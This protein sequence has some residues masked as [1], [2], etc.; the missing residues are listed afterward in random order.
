MNFTALELSTTFYAIQM[1][2]LRNDGIVVYVN[3]VER[4]RN[5]MPAGGVAYGTLASANI[6]PGAAEA[7]TTNLSPSFFVAG[8]N[9]IAVEVH[10][11]AANSTDMSFDMQVSG[12]DNNGTFNSS[13]AN[14]NI[15]SCSNILFAG[16]YWGA[17][18]GI[19]GTDSTWMTAGFNTVKLKLPGAAN[20]QTLTST[21]T[22]RH[23][24]AWSTAGFN[25][26]GYMCF[27]DITS[28][29]NASNAIFG[30][31]YTDVDPYPDYLDI[32]SDDDGIPDNVEGQSTTGYRLPGTVDTDGDGPVNTY[33]NIAGFSG[34]GI[35]VYD[36]DGDNTPDYRDSD[37]RC[38]CFDRQG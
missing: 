36:H 23:S 11:R 22:N 27:R 16:L 18:Q 33:D 6:A 32:D 38:R 28:I 19:S 13:T 21:Q 12:L 37:S 34:S 14:L 10:L 25:H 3:G 4:F 7:V 29:I 35:Y 9:T 24:L 31:L 26:T 17:D 15:P 5:N 20:Y 1:N 30:Q 8:V 2:L